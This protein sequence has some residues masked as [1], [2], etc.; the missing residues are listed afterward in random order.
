MAVGSW[1]KRRWA[2]LTLSVIILAAAGLALYW[3]FLVPIYQSPD[4]FLHLDYALCISERGGLYRA[5]EMKSWPG[6]PSYCA[7]PYTDYLVRRTD[8]QFVRHNPEA[9]V[10]P[11][12]GTRAYFRDLAR[13]APAREAVRVECAPALVSTYPCGYYSLLGFWIRGLRLV[14][15]NVVVMFFGARIF[16]VVLLILTLLFTYGTVRRLFGRRGF[17]LF[18][19]AAVGLLPLTTFVSSYVQPD[20]L[21]LTLTSACFYL[22]VRA[23]QEPGRRWTIALLGLALGG[24]LL[25]KVHFYLCVALAVAAMVVTQTLAAPQ[26][27]RRWVTTLGLLATPSLFAGWLDL[28]V[29]AGVT[30]PYTGLIPQG[31][32]TP[33]VAAIK[34]AFIEY[35]IGHT[36]D[37]FWG[38]F[39]WMDTPLVI[40][41]A[42]T[43]L[44]VKTFI[45][46]VSLALMVLTLLR[47]EQVLSRLFRVA[48]RGRWRTALRLL[49]ANP[50]ANSYVLFTV[51]MFGLYLKIGNAFGSQGRNWLPFL[52]P[53]FLLG[54]V[55]AP[56]ALTLRRVRRVASGLVAAA[57]AAFVLVGSCYAVRAIQNRFYTPCH[58]QPMQAH[59]LPT[60]PAVAHQVNGE[61]DNPFI[62]YALDQPRFVYGIRLTYR[63][64]GPHPEPLHV[65]AEWCQRVAGG[66]ANQGIATFPRVFGNN[67]EQTVTIWVNDTIDLFRIHPDNKPCRFRVSEVV[68]LERPGG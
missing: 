47:F 49:G 13:E 9:K 57:L 66:Y 12:Y 8:W 29:A 50:L 39:G 37:S 20:N 2:G 33:V 22:A 67:G 30:H 53:I 34:F 64:L 7:H 55:E 48:R 15:D 31:E 5:T 27:Q 44:N 32:R 28:W 40:G 56:K 46:A 52:L 1:V 38:T 11:A 63:V 24:L 51:V 42:R 59:P 41:D 62:V 18:M 16:S 61:G 45:L 36:H 17:A 19:T 6:Y 35:Y 4:E 43:D 23:R 10:S 60:T 68:L 21:S 3:V 65:R 25:T 54:I 14:T 58:G 26:A